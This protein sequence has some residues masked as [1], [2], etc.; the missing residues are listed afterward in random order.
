MGRKPKEELFP[1]ISREELPQ[2]L[3]ENHRLYTLSE[4][5]EITGYSYSQIKVACDNEG[6]I[7]IT[8]AERVKE[9]IECNMHLTLQQQADRLDMKVEG[10]RYYYKQ[11][12]YDVRVAGTGTKI[13]P[14]SRSAK[15]TA[16]RA[17]RE[18]GTLPVEL[19]LGPIARSYDIDANPLD[20]INSARN[21]LLSGKFV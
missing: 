14:S 6:L 12:G 19:A 20:V 10:L 8:L 4:M 2:Y 11:F 1:A 3:R 7:V 5:S 18:F 16:V 21:R 15:E 17:I 9:Y 13:I